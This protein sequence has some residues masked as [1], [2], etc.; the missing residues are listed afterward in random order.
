M[1]VSLVDPQDGVSVE[2][3]SIGQGR[4]TSPS[5]LEHLQGDYALTV[6]SGDGSS[7]WSQGFPLGFDYNGP[8][9]VDEDYSQ[10]QYGSVPVS[11][12]IPYAHAMH[13]VR[14][15]HGVNLIFSQILP[16]GAI[17][18]TVTNHDGQPVPDA[19]V[20]AAGDGHGSTFTDDDGRYELQGLDPGSY[21][22]SVTPPAAAHLMM[23]SQPVSVSA[24]QSITADFVLDS[25]GTID[26]RVTDA[27]GDPVPGVHLFVTGYETPQFQTDE[28]GRYAIPALVEGL[29]TLNIDS[30]GL[31]PWY[32]IVDGSRLGDARST[33][34][35][36]NVAL[37]TTVTVDFTLTIPTP[38]PNPTPHRR[39][40]LTPVPQP[41]A[42]APAPT[43]TPVATVVP[44]PP[45]PPPAPT[46]QALPVVQPPATGDGESGGGGGWAWYWWP[47]LARRSR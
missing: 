30:P 23:D 33:S 9:F 24:G 22:L 46:A 40:T 15:Y 8:V 14:L 41:T 31:G 10:I 37:G 45:A 36:V 11:F 20:E 39:P 25:A 1:L 2:N 16:V 7:L 6:V 27:N 4:A 32:I 5:V 47:L 43:A 35:D 12:R 34:V 28:D 26:G 42:T 18:G 19:L 13:E 44:P 38:T 3:V 21:A 29:Y 17:T